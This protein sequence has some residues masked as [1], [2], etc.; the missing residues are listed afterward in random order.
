MEHTKK[1]REKR[2]AVQPIKKKGPKKKFFS[3]KY[4]P[5]FLMFTRYSFLSAKTSPFNEDFLPCANL[6]VII[7][8][9]LTHYIAFIDNKAANNF[10]LWSTILQ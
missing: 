4:K 1:R 6:E 5:I 7:D 9:S 8:E 2:S 10:I 3:S